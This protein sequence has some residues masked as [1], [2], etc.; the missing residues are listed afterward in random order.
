[1]ARPN[2]PSRFVHRLINRFLNYSH[3][4]IIGAKAQ[5]KRHD[6]AIFVS[7]FVLLG[8]FFGLD[9]LVESADG[10]ST[11]LNRDNRTIAIDKFVL[12][13]IDVPTATSC[14]ERVGAVVSAHRTFV[15]YRAMSGHIDSPH[16]AFTRGR[17][18]HAR[19]LTAIIFFLTR[20][21]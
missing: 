15:G 5:K 6:D 2:S 12:L 9:A 16:F 19:E 10:T 13:E 14:A 11:Q 7:D 3:P 8:F 1:M 18:Y 17:D 20:F 4:L 21:S